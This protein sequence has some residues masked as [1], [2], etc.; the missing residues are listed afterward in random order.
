M[1]APPSDPAPTAVGTGGG[2]RLAIECAI[3]Y[4]YELDGEPPSKACD[5]PRC[6]Q[7]FHAACLGEVRPMPRWRA[8]PSWLTRPPCVCVCVCV[9]A[10]WLRA[11]PTTRQSY[12]TLFGACPYCNEVRCAVPFPL[13]RGPPSRCGSHARTHARAQSMVL[14]LP[15]GT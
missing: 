5:N 14:T 7:P 10:Q 3:C 4:A 8:A 13:P 2:A 11:L 1:P 15:A 12:Q 6:A 9:H